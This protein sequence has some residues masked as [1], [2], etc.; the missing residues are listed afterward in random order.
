MDR[1]TSNR[2]VNVG[3]QKG[4]QMITAAEWYSED[5]KRN[6]ELWKQLQELVECQS[7]QSVKSWLLAELTG[8]REKLMREAPEPYEAVESWL[9]AELVEAYHRKIYG[10][11]SEELAQL[12][13]SDRMKSRNTSD[14]AGDD[15][16][17]F[18]SDSV[19]GPY[20]QTIRESSQ[21]AVHILQIT[22]GR[23]DFNV[24]C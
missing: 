2:P 20:E 16:F 3:I 14:L 11:D 12:H 8:T 19:P 9:R 22:G 6:D 21:P 4:N 13:H 17:P 23:K 24:E 10:L 7:P 18:L 5:L 15:D 1:P